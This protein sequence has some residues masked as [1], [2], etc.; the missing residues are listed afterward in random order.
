M[1]SKRKYEKFFIAYV[2]LYW[3][4]NLKSEVVITA[5]I[6]YFRRNTQNAT[7]LKSAASGEFSN[8]PLANW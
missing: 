7:K 1:T 3:R 4:R 2:V 6:R 8:S 5:P